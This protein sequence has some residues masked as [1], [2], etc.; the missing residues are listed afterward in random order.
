MSDEPSSADQAKLV[1]QFCLGDRSAFAALV[2][3]WEHRLLTIA[4][5]VVG[6]VHDAEDVRQIVFL[7]LAQSPSQL[8]DPTRFA[9]WLRRCIVNEALTWLRRRDAEAKAK[10]CLDEAVASTSPSPS[11]QAVANEQS[12][13]L[14]HAMRQLDPES[15]ALLSLRFDE[16]LT[17]R[18]IGEVVEK[19]PMT[20]HSQIT[21]A[22]E[23]LRRLLASEH[24]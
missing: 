6:N 2:R 11:E 13:R 21:R 14:L 24:E 5:R 18:E 4:Y 17:I 1:Q 16:C 23:R 10:G 8:R 12:R 22:L 9:G 15:R 20:V 19:P 3:I 7:K